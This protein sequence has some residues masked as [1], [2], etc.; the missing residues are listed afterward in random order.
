M[1]CPKC[2]YERN[3][4]DTD[5][6]LC[7]I[8][9][10]YYDNLQAEKE[11]LKQRAK[12]QQP[13][14]VIKEQ[15][16]VTVEKHKIPGPEKEAAGKCP[17]CEYP[18]PAG[19]VECPN[20]RVIYINYEEFL[21]KQAAKEKARKDAEKKRFAE[22]KARIQKEAEKAIT[23]ERLKRERSIE[24]TAIKKQEAEEAE[25]NRKEEEEE[26]ERRNKAAEKETLKR[27][28]E[29]V[30]QAPG[31]TD[32]PVRS[33]G[34][35]FFAKNKVVSI[36]LAVVV[37]ASLIVPYKMYSNYTAQKKYIAEQ[38]EI[39]RIQAE[40][41]KQIT[42]EFLTNK[43]SIISYLKSLIDQRNFVFYKKEIRQYEIPSLEQYLIPVKSYLDEIKLYDSAQE[44]PAREYEKNYSIY[45]RLSQMNPG[46]KLY[47]KK[48]GYYQT[49][50]AKK[51]YN[52]ASAYFNKKKHALVEIES[53][54]AAANEA[55]ELN[56]GSKK[57][58]FLQ[59]KLLR[60]EL[61]FFKGNELVQ[62]AVRDAG[63]TRGS[64]GGQRKLY[65]WIKNV[66]S[67]TLYV[68]PDYFIMVGTNKKKYS[69]NHWDRKI[70]KNL[71]PGEKA[72][73]YIWF[74]TKTRP[75]QLFFSHNSAGEISRVFP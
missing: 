34:M 62:M 30:A 24:E 9:Y 4:S 59:H 2:G 60:E 53:A 21:A 35:G 61:L 45:T 46:S 36:L 33:T 27:E 68:N 18:R 1:E 48:R 32:A 70:V 17:K 7:G 26:E 13:P 31:E 56:K 64:T 42:Q 63:V 74:Y 16:T 75:Q 51:R 69:C 39:K 14:E 40:K 15:E 67:G 25:K 55:V 38:E 73:G 10:V 41:R 28:K 58:R 3:A 54:V 8:N 49:R 5:C 37:V 22:E 43:D 52:E 65:V 20:C 11:S 23:E 19:A 71:Q 6:P 50:L 57:Y 29:E 44:L 12:K 66:G 47:K 72:K